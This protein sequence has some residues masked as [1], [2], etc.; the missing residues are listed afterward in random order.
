M[1]RVTTA[2]VDLAGL[3]ETV[4]IIATDC[5]EDRKVVSARVLRGAIDKER[6]NTVSVA[7]VRCHFLSDAYVLDDPK[8]DVSPFA[9]QFNIV[10]T[11][12]L[13]DAA[14]E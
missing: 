1:R 13:Y 11:I 8:R 7:I 2:A 9:K 10:V 12:M 6:Y 4:A 5:V 3:A 14:L